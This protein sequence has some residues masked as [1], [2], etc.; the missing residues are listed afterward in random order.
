M[1]DKLFLGGYSEGGFATLAA[2][3]DWVSLSE[4]P[5]VFDLQSLTAVSAGA[6]AY[7][8]KTTF[9]AILQWDVSLANPSYLVMV[10][11]SYKSM[12]NISH[13]LE[14]IFSERNVQAI[15]K[16]IYGGELSRQEINDFLDSEPSKLFSAEFLEHY[17]DGSDMQTLGAFE[18]NRIELAKNSMLQE[19]PIR[20]FHGKE[21]MDVPLFNSEQM[22]QASKSTVAGNMELVMPEGVDHFEGS[23]LWLMDTLRFFRTFV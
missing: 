10:A 21:D 7:D 17:R 23:R 19:L 3:R 11:L 22:Y 6:G 20:L 2:L 12:Y 14:Y 15:Q 4:K 9:D 5:N 18:D 13:P 8:M 16:G 1:S